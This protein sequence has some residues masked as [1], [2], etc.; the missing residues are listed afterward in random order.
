M[1]LPRM[2]TNSEIAKN[3]PLNRQKAQRVVSQ[4]QR[5]QSS[6]F[7]ERLGQLKLC[8]MRDQDARASQQIRLLQTVH[9]LKQRMVKLIQLPKALVLLHVDGRLHRSDSSVLR[10][11]KSRYCCDKPLCSF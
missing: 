4:L 8:G 5:T 6:D 7:L 1:K 3:H 2:K 10:L 9:K 11:P